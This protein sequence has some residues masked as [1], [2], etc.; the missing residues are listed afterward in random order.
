M[1]TTRLIIQELLLKTYKNRFWITVFTLGTF[2]T[3]LVGIIFAIKSGTTID[4]A[5]KE[6]L[7]VMLGAFI[8]S[9]QR[10]IDFWFNNQERDKEVL[11]RA[12]EEDEELDRGTNLERQERQQ[13]NG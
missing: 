13:L 9:Y 10:V 11:R 2:L 7:L 12:D 5:W 4:G 1:K 8:G 6:I 3:A